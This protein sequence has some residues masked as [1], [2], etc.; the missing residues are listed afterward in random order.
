MKKR[1]CVNPRRAVNAMRDFLSIASPNLY[2]T[3]V[4]PAE[5]SGTR[6]KKEEFSDPLDWYSA[7]VDWELENGEMVKFPI[8]PKVYK[9]KEENFCVHSSDLFEDGDDTVRFGYNY[10]ALFDNSIHGTIVIIRDMEKREKYMRGFSRI[11][12]IL[13]HEMGH[14]ATHEEIYEK[15]SEEELEQLH[16]ENHNNKGGNYGYIHLPDEYA[17]TQW[18]I[19]WLK[20]PKNRKIA[21]AFE[22]KFW[23]CFV[24][25]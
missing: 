24:T 19:D 13:L 25:E 12:K 22:K 8:T 3:L 7:I 14:L 11:T 1:I 5:I 4:W 23:S 9:M 16:N 2:E 15:Y 18:A 21:K 20:N 6:P 10:E 17:A